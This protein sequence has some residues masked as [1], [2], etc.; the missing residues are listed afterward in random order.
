MEILNLLAKY[1]DA[2]VVKTTK[3]GKPF[4]IVIDGGP[5]STNEEIASYI[6]NLG[7]IDLMVLTHYDEDHIGGLLAYFRRFR[8]K[9]LPVGKL[10]CNCAQK[11]D[12]VDTDISDAGYRNAG[13]LAVY[14]REAQKFNPEF[15]WREDIC[16]PIQENGEMA[17]RKLDDGDLSI[18]ILSPTSEILS[19]LK[20]NYEDY[21]T[22]H[23]MK[24]DELQGD[25]LIASARGKSDLQSSIDD[26]AKSDKPRVSNLM[27]DSSIAFLLEAEGKKVLFMGDANPSVV[28]NAI[29]NIGCALPLKVDL[30]KVSHHGS[31]NNISFDLLNVIDCNKFAFSTNGGTGRSYHPDRK[32]LALILRSSNRKEQPVEFYFNYSL[33]EIQQRTDALLKDDEVTEENCKI[34]DNTVRITL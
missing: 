25:K 23:P 1:G 14:L 3:N 18:T 27:N 29:K 33:Q 5:V 10:W 34:I 16:V 31:K 15:E 32:T 9:T 21:L 6:T 2:I 28:A 12:F 11:I 8:G 30:T 24:I 26:L 7:Y 17:I 20:D 13:S 4:T 19:R 22:K